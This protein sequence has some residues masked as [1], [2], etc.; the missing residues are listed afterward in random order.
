MSSIA[1]WER[2][3]IAERIKEALAAK[4]ARGEYVGGQRRYSADDAALAASLRKRTTLLQAAVE[5]FDAGITTRDGG[6]LSTTQVARL[7]SA[8][9][10]R[11]T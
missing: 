1:E 9:N 7:A 4:K 8:H 6:I 11:E 2:E 10:E 5:L 3:R